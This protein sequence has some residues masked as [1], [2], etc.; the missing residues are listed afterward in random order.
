MKTCRWSNSDAA[1]DT[2]EDGEI[3]HRYYRVHVGGDDSNGTEEQVESGATPQ[4]AVVQTRPHAQWHEEMSA[5]A[6]QRCSRRH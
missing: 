1:A 2:E 3:A 4:W 6:Q 5:V